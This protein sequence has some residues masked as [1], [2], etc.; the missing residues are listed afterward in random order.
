VNISVHICFTLATGCAYALYI[1]MYI[2]IY[3]CI[4]IYI[5]MHVYIYMYVCMYM[6]MHICMDVYICVCICVCVCVYIYTYICMC[7]YVYI[8]I[9]IY[10]AC[11]CSLFHLL[12]G[13]EDWGVQLVYESACC[14]A[15]G[16]IFDKRKDRGVVCA[17]SIF[18]AGGS[19]CGSVC[20]YMHTHT[21]TTQM[22]CLDVSP[23]VGNRH[24]EGSKNPDGLNLSIHIFVYVHKVHLYIYANRRDE[25]FFF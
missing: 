8:Y 12:L 1:Y 13:N 17:F 3:V 25:I 16:V 7:I 10:I 21:H 19:V 2:C 22:G 6:C 14:L 5:C 9:Y 20:V 15:W 24:L 23:G 4:Y 11:M 18:N